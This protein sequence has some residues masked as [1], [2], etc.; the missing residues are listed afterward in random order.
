MSQPY[1][2]QLKLITDGGCRGNPGPGAIGIIIF[3]GSNNELRRYSACIG[4]TTNNQ[5]EYHALIKGLDI[6]ASFTRKKVVCMLDSEL[7]VKQMTGIWRLH[8]NDLRALFHEVKRNEE[9]FEEVVY[10]HV[11]R[12]HHFIQKAD[13]MVNEAFE[14]RTVE[15]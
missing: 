5:A 14:G 6:C 13:R 3:D 1:I 4:H 15:A 11:K 8:N 10:Q 12:T 9:P 7:V 2:D